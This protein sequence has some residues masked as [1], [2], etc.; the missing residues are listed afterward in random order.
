MECEYDVLHYVLSGWILS[1]PPLPFPCVP[2]ALSAQVAPSAT[3]SCFA[4]QN[5]VSDNNNQC[6]SAANGHLPSQLATQRP[7]AIDNQALVTTDP[8]KVSVY[9]CDTSSVYSFVAVFEVFA[10]CFELVVRLND[11]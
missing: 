4:R 5:N 1:I 6:F 2:A 3:E 11:Q 9:A 10:S 8:M 7:G